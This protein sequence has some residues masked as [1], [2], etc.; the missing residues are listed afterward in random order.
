MNVAKHCHVA[1]RGLCHLWLPC[2][3]M[4]SSCTGTVCCMRVRLLYSSQVHTVPISN[5]ACDIEF[6]L[7]VFG[8]IYVKSSWDYILS[9]ICPWHSRSMGIIWTSLILNSPLEY[10]ILINSGQLHCLYIYTYP[11]D[12][13]LIYLQRHPWHC[14]APPANAC[15]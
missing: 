15:Q 11:L 7:F 12:S 13:P 6:D 8:F 2:F 1:G 10:I 5:I 3:R 14:G 9:W 4:F